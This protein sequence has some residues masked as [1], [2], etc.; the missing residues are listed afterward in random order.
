MLPSPLPKTGKHERLCLKITASHV[1]TCDIHSYKQGF[2]GTPGWPFK[3][4]TSVQNFTFPNPET[5]TGV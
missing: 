2:I 3:A 4:L 1:P 5:G